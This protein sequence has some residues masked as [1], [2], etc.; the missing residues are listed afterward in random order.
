MQNYQRCSSGIQIIAYLIQLILFR[1]STSQT[2][3]S[4]LTWN[5][6]SIVQSANDKSEHLVKTKTTSLQCNVY[7]IAF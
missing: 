1:C 2:F 6:L 7:S 4:G 3:V 5:S